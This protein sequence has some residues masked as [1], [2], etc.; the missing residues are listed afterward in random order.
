MPLLPVPARPLT[1]VHTQSLHI[2]KPI[3]RS[4]GAAILGRGHRTSVLTS[5]CPSRHPAKTV[6]LCN[7][8]AHQYMYIPIPRFTVCYSDW[9]FPA[10]A[11][12]ERMNGPFPRRYEGMDTCANSIPHSSR[13]IVFLFDAANTI[14][15]YSS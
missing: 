10:H 1:L 9:S 2:R 14:P 11:V 15:I 12:L 8:E 6:L 7:D 4:T 13:R 3:G 5:V